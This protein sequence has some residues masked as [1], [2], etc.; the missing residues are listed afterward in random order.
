MSHRKGY[1]NRKTKTKK[2]QNKNKNKKQRRMRKRIKGRTKGKNRGGREGGRKG[3]DMYIMDK[4]TCLW[5][6]Y[7]LTREALIIPMKKML[8]N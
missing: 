6:T 2:I 3:R 7:I 5:R 1:V 4:D 8:S